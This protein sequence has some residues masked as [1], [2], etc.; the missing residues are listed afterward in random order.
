MTM[1]TISKIL[2]TTALCL[3]AVGG[4]VGSVVAEWVVDWF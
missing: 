1:P 2:A 4:F 3:A